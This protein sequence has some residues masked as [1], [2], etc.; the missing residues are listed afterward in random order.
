MNHRRRSCFCTTTNTITPWVRFFCVDF[1]VLVSWPDWVAL[2]A[3][4]PRLESF[5]PRRCVGVGL[6]DGR[7]GVRHQ[8]HVQGHR[9]HK[10]FSGMPLLC[11]VWGGHPRS[12]PLLSTD[13]HS[14]PFCLRCRHRIRVRRWT[15]SGMCLASRTSLPTRSATASA[16]ARCRA[17]RSRCGRRSASPFEPTSVADESPWAVADLL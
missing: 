13:P 7:P 5:L 14:L 17:S 16:T 15:R 9:R 11:L 6:R 1:V 8:S 4:L 3:H 10:R 2:L 12:S